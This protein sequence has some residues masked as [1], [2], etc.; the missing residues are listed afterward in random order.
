MER[1]YKE[2]EFKDVKLKKNNIEFC[3]TTFYSK[4]RKRLMGEAGMRSKEYNA[5][6]RM[7]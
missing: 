7:F 3:N 2:I 1:V 6:R 5:R 4:S